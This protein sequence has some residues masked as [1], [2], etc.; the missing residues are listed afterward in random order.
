[1][2][3]WLIESFDVPNDKLLADFNLDVLAARAVERLIGPLP[4]VLTPDQVRVVAPLFDI[5]PDR[6]ES[7]AESA[8]GVRWFD[9]GWLARALVHLV[10]TVVDQSPE[11]LVGLVHPISVNAA[12][13][14][15]NRFSAGAR[16]PEGEVY[17]GF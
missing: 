2:V 3:T 12:Q 11:D 4:E 5:E 16:I 6:W 15:L 1:M 8:T 9:S 13:G 14:L 10:R 17:I 7:I